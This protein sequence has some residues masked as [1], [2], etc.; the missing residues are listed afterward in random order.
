[1]MTL[2]FVNGVTGTLAT[3]NPIKRELTSSAIQ[4]GV[5]VHADV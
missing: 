3:V 4:G 2:D 1:M 5:T